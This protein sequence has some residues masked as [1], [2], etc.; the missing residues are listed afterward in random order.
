MAASSR[1]FPPRSSLS[2]RHV[3]RNLVAFAL[4]YGAG[5]AAV[6]GFSL[7]GVSTPSTKTGKATS[8][9]T[10]RSEKPH[11]AARPAP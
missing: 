8:V 4:L 6:W 5:L 11:T 7:L 1:R 2:A 3:L 10:P 9:L